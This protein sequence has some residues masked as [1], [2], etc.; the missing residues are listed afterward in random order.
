ML[1][2]ISAW[3]EPTRIARALRPSSV[4]PS[5]MLEKSQAMSH[6]PLV[7]VRERWMTTVRC[8]RLIK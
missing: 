2:T 7:L 4:I 6:L 1:P 3:F 8:G 5:W